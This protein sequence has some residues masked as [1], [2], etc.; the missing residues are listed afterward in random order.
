MELIN[1]VYVLKKVIDLYRSLNSS[2]F[3][4]FL[5]ASKA[6]DRVNHRALFLKLNEKGVPGYIYHV[7]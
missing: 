4:C 7:Y 3:V 1:H 2:V 6:F 5:D